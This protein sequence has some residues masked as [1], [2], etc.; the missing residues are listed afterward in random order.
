LVVVNLA[1]DWSILMTKRVRYTIQSLV[2][3]WQQ[4]TFHADELANHADE[5]AQD[6]D[7]YI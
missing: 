4:R 2:T 7:G 1:N 5:L 3:H 6:D